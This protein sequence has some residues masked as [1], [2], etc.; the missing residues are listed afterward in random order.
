MKGYGIAWSFWLNVGDEGV[1]RRIPQFENLWKLK[2]LF[3]YVRYEHALLNRLK[4]KDLAE[5][6]TDK[7]GLIIFELGF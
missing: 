6:K 2:K 5:Y 3:V 4:K 1:A 7:Y